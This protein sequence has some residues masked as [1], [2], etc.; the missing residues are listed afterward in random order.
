MFLVPLD[1]GNR[2]KKIWSSYGE[3]YG[4]VSLEI[5]SQYLWCVYLSN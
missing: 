4:W 1:V 3:N 5:S 2:I